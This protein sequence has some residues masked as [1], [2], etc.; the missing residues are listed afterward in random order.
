MAK[1]LETKY[2]LSG[3]D[4]TK[5]AFN[6]MKNNMKSAEDN[7]S[8]L[9]KSLGGMGKMLGISIA[10]ISVGGITNFISKTISAADATDEMADSLNLS[11]EA[12]SRLQYGASTAG[13]DADK[14]GVAMSKMNKTVS[15]AA[16]GSDAAQDSLTKLGLSGK[17]L[18]LLES[19]KKFY[20][21]AEAISKFKNS[22]EQAALAGEIFGSKLGYKLIPFIKDGAEGLAEFAKQ[23][24]QVGYTLSDSVIDKA[25]S[26]ADA[27]VALK[28][29]V[30]GFGNI[31]VKEFGDEMQGVIQ[32]FTD[33]VKEMGAGTDLKKFTDEVTAE[34][35]RM[36][37][38]GEDK[39]FTKRVM[40]IPTVDLVEFRKYAEGVVTIKRE[41]DASL[42]ALEK[43]TTD[44]ARAEILKK[45]RLDQ[46]NLKQQ[47]ESQ[48]KALESLKKFNADVS[49]EMD[50]MR[51]FSL[52]L[53]FTNGNGL[54]PVAFRQYAESVVT[55][56]NE[57]EALNAI[58]LDDLVN[59]S[60]AKRTALLLKAADATKTLNDAE[61][62]RNDAKDTLEALKQ[63][64]SASLMAVAMKMSIPVTYDVVGP[65]GK[66]VPI[67]KVGTELQ[68]DI[69]D[70]ISN[71]LAQY[72]SP[73]LM[74]A[75]AYYNIPTTQLGY[76]K[77]A[78]GG[79]EATPSQIP[80]D[81]QSIQTDV[82]AATQQSML[83][84]M[85]IA[86]QFQAKLMELPSAAQQTA[87]ALYG[88]FD[89][90][91]SG[92]ADVM[93]GSIEQLSQQLMGL[94]DQP[95]MIGQ[96]FGNMVASVIGDLA[97]MIL[98]MWIVSLLAKVLGFQVG[99]LP[100]PATLLGGGSLGGRAAG[101][102]ID[103]GQSFWVG[104][105][106]RELFTPRVAGNIT[107]EKKI[108][109]SVSVTNH[110]T[111]DSKGDI[112]S[113]RMAMNRLAEVINDRIE[114]SV[115]KTYYQPA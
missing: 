44:K 26:A 30:T 5:Q 1:R 36:K 61:K 54:D 6:S 19:D 103:K 108:G 94:N 21:I 100:A 106:G 32:W 96:A 112:F 49:R 105:Q 15:D 95:I 101:G 59:M 110:I 17:D 42:A 16:S 2:V 3:E 40:G 50:V 87:E 28:A 97:K 58:P 24:D 66:L 69:A 111:I 99:K 88:A 84:N 27:M 12:L 113:N 76:A 81:R 85:S 34:M 48:K 56:R 47:Q 104:E 43:D 68:Q 18:D 114:N 33:R 60:L 70:Y 20:A 78:D 46:D 91:A 38:A 41:N 109:S 86:D 77:T 75:A 92:I 8:K 25:V 31:V 63:A 74:A 57:L 82:M 11:V 67:A 7:V 35:K 52:D 71:Q 13:I 23:S 53:T 22:S 90:A 73:E 115:K 4:K 72:K 65:D 39:Q 55:A 80:R 83:A 9:N 107:P 102:P 79:N 98:K 14:F 89:G 45:E 93:G 29:S 37:A 64:P 51:G 10:A 62:K